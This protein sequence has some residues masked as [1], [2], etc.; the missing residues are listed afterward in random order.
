LGLYVL[1]PQGDKDQPYIPVKGELYE[2]WNRTILWASKE[3]FDEN[4]GHLPLEIA[5]KVWKYNYGKEQLQV[6]V[7]EA[8]FVAKAFFFRRIEDGQVI[9]LSMWPEHIPTILPRT[10]YYLLGREYKKLFKTIKDQVLLPRETFNKHFGEYFY[11]YE[12]EESVIIHPDK[13][14]SVKKVFNSVT[15]NI[16]FEQSFKRIA[17]DAIANV[18]PDK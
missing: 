5:T 11:S 16:S 17:A 12:Y 3:Y 15:S 9:T 13:A 10:D 1:N 14:A 2:N 7:G 6:Q 8:Y 4:T 18:L